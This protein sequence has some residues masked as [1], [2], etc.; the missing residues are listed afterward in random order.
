[1]GW[2]QEQADRYIDAVRAALRDLGA[3]LAGELSDHGSELRMKISWAD[4]QHE[5]SKAWPV[6]SLPSAEAVTVQ[7]RR[8]IGQV[9]RRGA[10]Q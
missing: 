3:R 7:I 8:V 4:H 2:T 6:D 1:M 9:E 5:I 10:T